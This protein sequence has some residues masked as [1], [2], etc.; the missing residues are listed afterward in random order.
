M[1]RLRGD[2]VPKWAQPRPS[3]EDQVAILEP[4]DASSFAAFEGFS[5]RPGVGSA[6]PP[7]A[8]GRLWGH[9]G[10]VRLPAWLP[11]RPIR[12]GTRRFAIYL[13]EQPATSRPDRLSALHSLGR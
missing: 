8:S 10:S 2:L 11:V 4:E 6:A 9:L 5:Y 3:V 13:N 12:I 7:G 1:V